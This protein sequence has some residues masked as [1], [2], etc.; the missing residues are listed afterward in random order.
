VNLE[1]TKGDRHSLFIQVEQ[2]YSIDVDESGFSITI[3]AEGEA[4]FDGRA[5]LLLTQPGAPSSQ[6]PIDERVLDT[7]LDEN[8]LDLEVLYIGKS[9]DDEGVA[10]Q[11][12]RAH[13][14]LQRIL[15]DHMDW[16]PQYELPYR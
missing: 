5:S 8:F 15:A 2:G 1:N 13:S 6:L 16:A 12:L 4:I 7:D 3:S 10:H 9:E 14:T 11:R